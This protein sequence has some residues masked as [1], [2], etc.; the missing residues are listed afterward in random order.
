M[1]STSSVAWLVEGIERTSSSG[2]GM[3]STCSVAWLVEGIALTS[4]SGGGL[5]S[6]S[7]LVELTCTKDS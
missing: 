1:A 2:G 7:T 6:P 4:S 3:T 5:L